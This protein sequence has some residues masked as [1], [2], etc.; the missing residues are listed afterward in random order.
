[1][2]IGEKLARLPRDGK[3]FT[4]EELMEEKLKKYD[5]AGVT[6]SYYGSRKQVRYYGVSGRIYL[7]RLNSNG[8]TDEFEIDGGEFGGS[9]VDMDAPG[10]YTID[11][12]LIED[13]EDVKAILKALGKKK[14][15]FDSRDE[16][17]GIEHLVV[18]EY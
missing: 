16:V 10:R 14:L 17:R 11:P 7:R 3:H 8:M 4:P 1:M 9:G 12:D 5:T 6:S 13:I 15:S 2:D 18:K